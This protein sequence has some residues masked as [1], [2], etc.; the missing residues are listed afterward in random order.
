[1][2]KSRLKQQNDFAIFFQPKRMLRNDTLDI[3]SN[4]NGGLRRSGDFKWPL[5]GTK[6]TVWERGTRGAAFVHGKLLQQIGVKNRE[7]LPVT[8]WYPTLI[9]LAGED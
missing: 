4:D 7:L 1:M 6:H 3:L 2:S 5:R 9:N 8:D